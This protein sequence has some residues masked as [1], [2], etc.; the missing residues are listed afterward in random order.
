[1]KA[2]PGMLVGLLLVCILTGAWA[3]VYRH[4]SEVA[5]ATENA[6]GHLELKYKV[7]LFDIAVVTCFHWFTDQRHID[8][9]VSRHA[10]DLCCG[11]KLC[12]AAHIKHLLTCL[13]TPHLHCNRGTLGTCFTTLAQAWH[14]SIYQGQTQGSGTTLAV[15]AVHGTWWNSVAYVDHGN[16][17]APMGLGRTIGH[18]WRYWAVCWVAWEVGSVGDQL[19]RVGNGPPEVQ[20]V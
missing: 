5:G 10:P 7:R 13:P 18:T 20:R 15:S 6:V 9:S 11:C 4:P 12:K 2:Q 3:L 8:Q 17:G 1:M 16:K 19:L 14:F